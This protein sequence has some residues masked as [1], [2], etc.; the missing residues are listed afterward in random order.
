VIEFEMP[1]LAEWL[2]LIA[3]LITIIGG[4]IRLS[5]IMHTAIHTLKILVDQVKD[6]AKCNAVQDDRLSRIETAIEYLRE[7]VIYNRAEKKRG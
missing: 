2:G 6:L 1:R 3:L 4:G 7:T 5:A